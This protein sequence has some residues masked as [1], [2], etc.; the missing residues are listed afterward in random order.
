MALK[1][2][3]AD[4]NAEWMQTTA[5]DLEA[6]LY[7]VSMVHN[8]RDCQL[9]L[10]NNKYF[11]VIL[12][13]D[14]QNHSGSQVLTF[15]K[16]NYPGQKLILVLE[17][18]KKV[19]NGTI[20]LNKLEKRGISDVIIKPFDASG[21]VEALEGQQSIGDIVTGLEIRKGVSEEVD[22][23]ET[24]ANFTK[25]KIEDFYS[26]QAVLFDIYIKLG[27]DKYTKILHAR[28]TFSPERIDKYKDEK[29]VEYLYFNV[30]D[31]RKYIQFYNFLAVK[32]VENSKVPGMKKAKL[33]KNITDKLL[34]DTFAV[35]MK[36]QIIDQSKAVCEN[37]YNMVESD[38][39]LNELLKKFQNF[40]PTAFTHSFLTTVFTSAIIKQF[41]WQSKI[42]M[43]ITAMASLFHDIGKMKLPPEIA[44]KNP[45]DMTDEERVTYED[46]PQLGADLLANHRT[47]SQAVRQIIIQHHEA[48]DGTG[49]PYK[50]KGRR[51]LTLANILCLAND[52]VHVMIDDELTPVDALKKIISNPELVCRYNSVIIENFIKVF[53]DPIQVKKMD[54]E[55]NKVK[56]S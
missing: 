56:V 36:P 49:F 2:L 24:D 11:A 39:K 6:A 19:E 43:E 15:I 40:D 54:A 23:S 18:N 21:L 32:M 35:G 52:F 12:N 34:E 14:L 45:K 5:K 30:K 28:D 8:G 55:A 46:H 42:T 33:L 38:D 50:K 7:D 47:I 48:F 31:R 26:S 9:A 20:D 16:T 53:V 29:G 17:D 44:H 37:V 22:I 41:D 51:I 27:D 4:P 3:I 10:Y 13:W 1:L 25:I